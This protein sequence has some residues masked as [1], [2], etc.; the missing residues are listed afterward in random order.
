M[1]AFNLM[2]FG[3]QSERTRRDLEKSRCFAEVGPRFDSVF[4]GSVD[5]NAVV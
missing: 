5:A 2:G 1:N 4:G 3:R